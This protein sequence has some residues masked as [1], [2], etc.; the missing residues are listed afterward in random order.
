MLGIAYGPGASGLISA[1]DTNNGNKG[2]IWTK[3]LSSNTSNIISALGN[4]SHYYETAGALDYNR[5]AAKQDAWMSTVSARQQEGLI[6]ENVAKLVG[7]AMANSGASGFDVSS[8]STQAAI[9]SIVKAGAAD[10]AIIRA[11]GDIGAIRSKAEAD[12]YKSQKRTSL[13]STAITTAT[14]LFKK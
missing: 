4:I 8:E 1:Q 7:N 2:S 12:M 13:L 10:A 6:Y 5:I 3:F 11:K 14:D 9:D